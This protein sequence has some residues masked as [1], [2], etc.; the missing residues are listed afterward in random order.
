MRAVNATKF[1]RKF[2][3]SIAPVNNIISQKHRDLLQGQV[4]CKFLKQSKCVQSVNNRKHKQHVFRNSGSVNVERRAEV[5]KEG[6]LERGG[7]VVLGLLERCNH[8]EEIGAN[9]FSVLRVQFQGLN[10]LS[11]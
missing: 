8:H 2:S 4:P 5:G 10:Q 7:L 1:L 3:K 11:N 6:N 9:N